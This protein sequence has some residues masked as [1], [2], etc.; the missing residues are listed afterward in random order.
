MLKQVHQPQ[1][2]KQ[3][4]NFHLTTKKKRQEKIMPFKFFLKKFGRYIAFQVFEKKLETSN[5][6]VHL[7]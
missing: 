5:Q 3:T 1:S 2:H 4:I 6:I 7:E